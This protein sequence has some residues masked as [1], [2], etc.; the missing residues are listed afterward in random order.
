MGGG[1]NK[2]DIGLKIQK[3]ESWDTSGLDDI[4]YA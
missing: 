1:L 4:D 2:G 3:R